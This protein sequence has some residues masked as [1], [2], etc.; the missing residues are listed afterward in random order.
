MSL[1]MVLFD[2]NMQMELD[3]KH[4]GLYSNVLP[5]NFLESRSRE[6]GCYNDC[7]VLLFDRHIGSAAADVP[8]KFQSDRKSLN[9]S[10]A[11]LRLLEIL[12]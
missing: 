5:P 12:R 9:L 1:V 10:L 2:S 3:V 7:I 4:H 6:I 11:V 8:V